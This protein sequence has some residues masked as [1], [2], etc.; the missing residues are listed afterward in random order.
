M[1]NG[2]G[3]VLP[4]EAEE[5][6]DELWVKLHAGKRRTLSRRHIQAVAQQVSEFAHRA[7]LRPE[8]LIVA[9]K[10]SW[11]RHDAAHAHA[12]EHRVQWALTEVLSSCI[13]EFYRLDSAADRDQHVSGA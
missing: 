12:Q 4:A 9:V 8:D 3:S 6:L 11:S 2:N 5:L 1:L 7:M 13:V 10:A